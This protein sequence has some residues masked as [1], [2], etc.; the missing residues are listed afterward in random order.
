[1]GRQVQSQM[2]MGHVKTNF[3]DIYEPYSKFKFI[4]ETPLASWIGVF[5]FG[6]L[7]L[8]GLGFGLGFGLAL[9]VFQQAGPGPKLPPVG[10]KS[11]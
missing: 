8:I 5:A 9:Q 4:Q 11:G 3:L 10:A 7:L 2:D 6:G 1:M